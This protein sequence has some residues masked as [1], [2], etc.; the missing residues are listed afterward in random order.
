M[1]IDIQE[2]K[3]VKVFALSGEIDMASSPAL[4]SELMALVGRK[5]PV[6]FVDFKDVSY[7]DSSGIA[8]F[9]EGLKAMMP[10]GGR[11]KLL[12]VPA[13]IMEIFNFSKLDKVFEIYGNVEDAFK[14]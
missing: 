2:H 7:I 3:G 4:R 6:V 14:G 10:Y 9:V 5:A 8:T 13:K 1:K 12:G 11:L